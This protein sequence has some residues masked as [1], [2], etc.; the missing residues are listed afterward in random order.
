MDVV[1]L[2]PVKLTN[3]LEKIEILTSTTRINY[4]QI[5]EDISRNV[6]KYDKNFKKHD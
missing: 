1:H 4:T 2:T 3:T 5:L 6:I